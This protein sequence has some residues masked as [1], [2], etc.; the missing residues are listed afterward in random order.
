MRLAGFTADVPF[1][2]QHRYSSR[3]AHDRAER[4][5]ITPSQQETCGVCCKQTLIGPTRCLN[6]GPCQPW[7]HAWCFCEYVF[8]QGYFPRAFCVG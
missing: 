4:T 1:S 5:A 6:S 2:I 7:Q 3:A 8:M